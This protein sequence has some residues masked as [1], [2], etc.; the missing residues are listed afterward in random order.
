MSNCSIQLYLLH[1]GLFSFKV[2]NCKNHKHH[3]TKGYVIGT[4]VRQ[5]LRIVC[6][7]KPT[8]ACIYFNTVPSLHIIAIA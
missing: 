3:L 2:I 6:D 5:T 4:H 7:E 8:S 1:N